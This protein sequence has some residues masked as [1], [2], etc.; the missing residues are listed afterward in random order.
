MRKQEYA[1]SKQEYFIRKVFTYCVHGSSEGNMLCGKEE[2]AMR[3]GIYSLRA[4]EFWR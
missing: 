4:L 1:I 2:Y 3:Q